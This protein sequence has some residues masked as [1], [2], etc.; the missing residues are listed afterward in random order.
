MAGI[1]EAPSFEQLQAQLYEINRRRIEAIHS[2][3]GNM[4]ETNDARSIYRGK[5]KALYEAG[6]D[7]MSIGAG[8]GEYNKQLV[9]NFGKFERYG[10]RFVMDNYLRTGYT[11]ITRPELNLTPI[12]VRQHRY[13][14]LLEDQNPNHIQFA[15]KAYLDTRFCRY[16]LEKVALCPYI[17][18]RSPFFNILMNN[19]QDFSGGPSYQLQ[20]YTDEEG[21]FGEAQ[22]IASGS[23]SFRKP[24][25]LQLGFADPAGGPISAIFA[26]WLKYIEFV[27]IGLM[28][29][30]PDQMDERVLNYTVSIYRFLM[31]P[32]F[33]Y[34]R[35][36]AKYTGCFPINHPGA[37]VFDFSSKGGYVDAL[38]KF[39]IGFR[40]GSGQVDID[41]PVV[42][43]E[44]N[45]LVERYFAPIKILRGLNVEQNAFDEG[46]PVVN[47]KLV[48]LDQIDDT[49][50]RYG[51]ARNP[52]IPE[53]NF[54]GVP[55]ILETPNGFR[56]DVIREIDETNQ[57]KFIVDTTINSKTGTYDVYY[58]KMLNAQKEL[59][60]YIAGLDAQ[61]EYLINQYRERRERV[62]SGT[63]ETTKYQSLANV[64]TVN[65]VN[66][67]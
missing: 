36:W 7:A 18:Y 52:L 30:Y 14:S 63:K 56:L 51:M 58:P 6:L 35:R 45:T 21:Y 31:D 15:I 32:S 1:I 53:L 37:T 33:R 64:R 11:F 55:Y 8:W 49:L 25:D 65:G 42:L 5:V 43:V 24:F 3:T 34:I 60:E 44:F 62:M 28:L 39:S 59:F 2:E 23:D 54:T 16:N 67:I 61:Q 46:M 47:R 48:S 40:C 57:G 4:P 41:D 17:D 9:N 22:S 50:A 26:F 66:Y 38:R 27:N 29:M 10:T 13:M 12:N 19:L 20:T